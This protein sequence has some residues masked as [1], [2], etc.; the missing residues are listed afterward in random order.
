M[1]ASA[2]VI[3][4]PWIVK[5]SIEL[6]SSKYI[7]TYNGSYV[8][9]NALFIPKTSFFILFVLDS[10]S[11]N[12]FSFLAPQSPPPHDL[13]FPW[14]TPECIAMTDTHLVQRVLGTPVLWAVS[15]QRGSEPFSGGP[16]VTNTGDQMAGG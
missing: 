4:A 8:R 13:A 15:K 9:E 11:A 5:I 10:A 16:Q 7:W 12:E 3:T 6:A 2:A 14:W 1:G